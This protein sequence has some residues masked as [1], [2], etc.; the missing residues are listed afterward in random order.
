M[1]ETT[2][3]DHIWPEYGEIYLKNSKKVD[4]EKGKQDKPKLLE[5]RRARGDPQVSGD[6]Q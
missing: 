2:R 3:P 5:A 6:D 1:Q 4:I